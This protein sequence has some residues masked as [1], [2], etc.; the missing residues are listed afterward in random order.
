L[1]SYVKSSGA[2][3]LHVCVPLNTDTTYAGSKRYARAIA[4][5]LSRQR[6]DVV[7]TMTKSLR[8]GK[9]FVDW[10]QNDPGKSTVAPYSLRALRVPTVAAPL[11]WEEVAMAAERDDPRPLVHG[12]NTVF[13][14]VNTLGDLFAPVLTER[15]RLPAHPGRTSRGSAR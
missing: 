3:G 9:V 8:A 2:K 6:E 14:R 10:S 12:I 15:Q 5:T 4:A 7:D 1:V 13:D 11:T